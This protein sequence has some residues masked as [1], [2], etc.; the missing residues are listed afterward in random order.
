MKKTI[1]KDED[2]KESERSL[3]LEL[4]QDERYL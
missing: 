1:A 3:V 2:E 4:E